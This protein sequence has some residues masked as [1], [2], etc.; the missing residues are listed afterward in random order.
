M[1]FPEVR[2]LIKIDTLAQGFSCEISKK[3]FCYRSPP[4][5]ASVCCRRKVAA[6]KIEKLKAFII[7]YY[8]ITI[9]FIKTNN[10]NLVT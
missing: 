4:V 7:K 10:I 2:S 3:T 5:A 6:A 9:L 1:C 8:D